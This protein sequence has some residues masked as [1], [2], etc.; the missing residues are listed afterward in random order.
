[1][2]AVSSAE[3]FVTFYQTTRSHNPGDN[4][5]HNHLSDNLKAFII[6]LLIVTHAAAVQV[7]TQLPAHGFT[8]LHFISI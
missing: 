2:E 7:T 5:F 1:M 6:R 3:T 4:N 8:A